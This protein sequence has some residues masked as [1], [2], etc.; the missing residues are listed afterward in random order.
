MLNFQSQL[1]KLGK[2]KLRKKLNVAKKA[3]EALFQ[4]ENAK[5]EVLSL[6][7]LYYTCQPLIIGFAKF[8][9]R[10]A[11]IEFRLFSF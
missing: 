10:G 9:M 11:R 7:G 6:F 3:G 5:Q 8:V 4:F 1:S 2:D